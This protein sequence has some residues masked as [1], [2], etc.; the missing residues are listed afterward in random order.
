MAIHVVHFLGPVTQITCDRTV[1]V[2]LNARRQG[3][4]EI[5]FHFSSEGGSTSLGFALFNFLRSLALPII[6][7]NVGNIESMAVIVYLAASRRLTCNNSRFLIHPLHFGF[8]GI[9]AADHSRI[10]EWGQG[11]DSDAERY[12]KIFDNQT[13]NSI[14]PIKVKEHL[15]GHAAIIDGA[16]AVAGGIAHEICDASIPEGAITWWV[17]AN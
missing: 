10:L 9:A 17:L 6:M 2:C 5:R 16:G 4:T 8:V 7:H 11:L 13:L 1:D 15:F 14:K 12:A 3:A